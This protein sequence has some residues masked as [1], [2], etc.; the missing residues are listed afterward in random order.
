LILSADPV[1]EKDGVKM[2]SHIFIVFLQLLSDRNV[3]QG[4]TG[5]L[6]SGLGNVGQCKFGTTGFLSL[7]EMHKFDMSVAED[8]NA[9]CGP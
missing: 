5:I 8:R 7:A 4:N 1:N 9:F 3:I 6:S 2:N